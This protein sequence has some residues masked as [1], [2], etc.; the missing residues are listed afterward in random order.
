[1]SD[2]SVHQHE[3]DPDPAAPG[4]PPAVEGSPSGDGREW[5]AQLQHMIDRITS[6]AGPAAR[7]VAAKAAELAA[8][9]GQK[10][11]PVA[12]DV[13]T[14]AA[15]LAAVAGEKA[16]PIAKR[17]AAVTGDVGSRVA[18]RSRRLAEDLRHRGAEGGEPAADAPEEGRSTEEPT[19]DKPAG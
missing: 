15:D 6:E 17:A 19:D 11:G 7:D 14:K 5:I 16:G 2:E 8:V 10:A 1:M 9:A 13:A 12:R 18:D 4:T 3:A